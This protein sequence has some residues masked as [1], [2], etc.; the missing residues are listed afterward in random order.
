[1]LQTANGMETVGES[2]DVVIRNVDTSYS[3]VYSCVAFKSENEIPV[4]KNVTVT[5]I[6][7]KNFI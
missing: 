5:V 6:N 3:G 1:M 4:S 2:A 7:G